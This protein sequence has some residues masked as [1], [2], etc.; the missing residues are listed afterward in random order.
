MRVT[1]EVV[2]P[3]G[4]EAE[5]LGGGTAMFE[6]FLTF[7]Q[8]LPGNTFVQAKAGFGIPVESGH[9]NEGFWRVAVGGTFEQHRF[10][11][12]WTPML[13]VLAARPLVSRAAIEWELLPGAQVTLHTRQHVRLA[14]GVRVP[15][16]EANQR[17]TSVIVYLLWDWYEG[18][19]FK[20]W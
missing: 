1:G 17:Q 7:G 16:T 10:G 3:T 8:M 13:E 15:V 2:L 18:G 9:D 5:E 12:L 6:P 11:R 4:S 20:G 19:F 14:G